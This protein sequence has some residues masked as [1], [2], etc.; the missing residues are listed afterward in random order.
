MDKLNKS[1][2][3]EPGFHGAKRFIP[4]ALIITFVAIGTFFIPEADDTT[5]ANRQMTEDQAD[6]ELHWQHVH[7]IRTQSSIEGAYKMQFMS[8][9]YTDPIEVVDEHDGSYIRTISQVSQ[10]CLL[11]EYNIDSPEV[12]IHESPSG[13]QAR[14]VS[15]IG[16]PTLNFEL[17]AGI[18]VAID[19]VTERTLKRNLCNNDLGSTALAL[20]E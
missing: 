1:M 12:N 7:A 6:N 3:T 16:E 2:I 10:P 13:D 8:S 11:N 14:I 20:A 4:S 15:S 19:E 5:V 17:L 9:I 18:F